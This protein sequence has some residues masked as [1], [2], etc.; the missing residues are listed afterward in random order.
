MYAVPPE[1]P[2]PDR[3]KRTELKDHQVAAAIREYRERLDQG[4]AVNR[5]DFLARHAGIASTLRSL[6]AV[7]DER[8]QADVNAARKSAG[9][10]TRSFVAQDL[11]TVAPRSRPERSSE[12]AESGFSEQFGRYRIVRT[13]GRGG[14]GTVYLAEDTKLKRPVA[15]KTPH[16]DDEPSSSVLA[17]FHR[18]ARA[19]ATLT[20]SNI[21]PIYDVG[22][23]DGKHYIAM[24]YIEGQ[25]LS[26]LIR[27]NKPLTERQ[28]LIFLHKL[29][30]AIQ[31]AHDHKIVHRDLKPANIMVDKQNEPMIMDFGLARQKKEGEASLTQSGVLIGSPAY[32]SPEQVATDAETVGP[33]SDQYSLGVVLYELLTGQLPFRGS[34]G[35]VLAQILTK[36]ATP[37]SQ[38]RAGLDPRIEAIC[39]RMMAKRAV[40]R[41]DSLRTLAG[42]V[43]KIV[44]G[45]G[46]KSAVTDK[47]PSALDSTVLVSHPSRLDQADRLE[48]AALAVQKAEELLRIKPGHPRT[49]ETRE[50]NSG[51]RARGEAPIGAASQR[52]EREDKGGWIPWTALAFGIAVVAGMAGVL[53]LYLGKTA[54][55]IDVQ[56]PDI[57]VAV[58]AQ[59]KVITITGPRE[60]KVTVEPGDRHLKIFHGGLEA[61]TES[62]ELKKGEKRRV[63][64]SLVG[65]KLAAEIDRQPLEVILG[66]EKRA[67][68]TGAEPVVGPVNAPAAAPQSP[69]PRSAAP[70]TDSSWKHRLSLRLPEP[71]PLAHFR[72][73][74]SATNQAKGNAHWRLENTAFREDSLYLNGEY[75]MM[76]DRD[77][78]GGYVAVCE[79]PE[80]Q[81]KAFTVFIRFKA[82]D[83]VGH[84]VNLLTGGTATRWFG[85]N[86]SATGFLTITLNNQIFSRDF[87]NAPINENQWN[88]VGCGIDFPAGKTVIYLNGN[89]VADFDLSKEFKLTV[90]NSARRD[91]DKVW[92][93][94][95]YANGNVF[96]GFINELVLYDRLL[97]ADEFKQAFSSGADYT[98]SAP[99]APAI[100]VNAPLMPT[101]LPNS[102]VALPK[103]TADPS[104][105]NHPDHQAATAVL[106]LGGSVTLR[107]DGQ[108]RGFAPGNDLPS[109]P[110]QL[111]QANL[112]KGRNLTDDVL[113]TLCLATNLAELDF[114]G[115]EIQDAGLSHLAALKNLRVLKLT[116]AKGVTDAG[117]AHLRGL[118]GLRRLYLART[119]ITGACLAHV[120]GMTQLQSLSVAAAPV[121]GNSLVY[122]EELGHLED[123][124]LSGTRVN[125]AGLNHL[126]NLR[127]LKTLNLWS[128]KLIGDAGLG[129]LQN[130][131]LRTLWLTGSRITDRGLAHLE[132]MTEL[133]DL[134]LGG[135]QISDAGLNHLRNLKQL[136]R[137]ALGD[138]LVSNA[139]LRIVK[140]FPRLRYLYL[141]GTRVTGDG[142]E[143]LKDL[144][145]L[146]EL[147][148][149]NTRTHDTDLR[150][151]AP[152][153][154]LSVLGL[155]GTQITDA[156]LLSLEGLKE[157]R[158]LNLENTQVT[159]AGV[160]GLWKSLPA[161][162]V[163]AHPP[164][165]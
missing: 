113:A 117:V 70:E 147:D 143:L 93:F 7:E 164:A 90:V 62:F 49:R 134:I 73:G 15:I 131:N 140:G 102:T 74:V 89:Q 32:M 50:K 98:A 22:E 161:C 23:I 40:D 11:E 42:E 144:T 103:T 12:S 138:T 99:E 27:G 16:F 150:R 136:D 64:V 80:F 125:D 52:T 156:G 77:K 13:L 127:E 75:A 135:C 115:S 146:I 65:G 157:L 106:A 79:T 84:H 60:E 59:G 92:T 68:R 122:L 111:T 36:E 9:L 2:V 110:F 123:L 96:H 10:S 129:S 109:G 56:D 151:L 137:L 155:N 25:P 119:G 51:S 21:C 45:R 39:V 101:G 4:E 1:S 35:T 163:R 8:R 28:V 67:P 104:S 38:L 47:R 44:K 159:K 141:N 95:N 124:D 41:F 108:E 85:L 72:F 76:D 165:R 118:T 18:E 61:R 26:A 91:T 128:M 133:R 83:F 82:A 78:A 31:E 19:A 114:S 132:R 160:E 100:S 81:Y 88:V 130:L 55:V 30:L 63:K 142:L 158:D 148:L 86:R 24:A 154:K 121:P 5:E 126:R 29:A 69:D 20:H 162:I 120:A 17:R 66:T 145:E 152:F 149:R 116:D 97:S 87:S 112:A 139:G 48:D 14:M 94:T 107:A 33:A 34:V 105:L 3:S 43:A 46:P 54:V 57:N 71:V 53:V 153:R 6:I 37:P 58:T